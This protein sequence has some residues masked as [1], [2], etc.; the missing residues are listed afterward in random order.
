MEKKEK[1]KKINNILYSYYNIKRSNVFQISAKTTLRNNFIDKSILQKEERKKKKIKDIQI[2][3]G[4]KKK[5]KKKESENCTI[6][7]QLLRI[8]MRGV[9]RN[10]LN[11][12]FKKKKVL[13]ELLQIL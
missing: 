12:P 8:Q 2:L 10:I 9:I 11:K 5:K 7:L 13:Q 4:C 3:E 1:K 6:F